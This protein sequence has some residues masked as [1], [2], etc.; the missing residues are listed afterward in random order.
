MI[1]E[2]WIKLLRFLDQNDC[3]ELLFHAMFYFST[4][5][6]K[7]KLIKMPQEVHQELQVGDWLDFE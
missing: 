6:S 4:E 3:R 7:A 2:K 1:T 5:L